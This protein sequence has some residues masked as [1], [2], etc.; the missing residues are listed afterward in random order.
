MSKSKAASQG[1]RRSSSQGRRSNNPRGTA[2]VH[3]KFLAR[4][5]VNTTPELLPPHV[6]DKVHNSP[7]YA[8]LPVQESKTESVSVEPSENAAS[9]AQDAAPEVD[10]KGDPPELPESLPE[11]P[12]PQNIS[13]PAFR[14]FRLDDP[15]YN[16]SKDPDTH[17]APTPKSAQHGTQRQASTARLNIAKEELSLGVSRNTAY[18]IT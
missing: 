5:R 12:S 14:D 1:N 9:D 17:N 2:Q 15:E 16:L 3:L 11:K 8:C 4:L 6:F 13:A 18:G 10:A 7:T